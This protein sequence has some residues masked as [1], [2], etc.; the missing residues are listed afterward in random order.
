MNPQSRSIMKFMVVLTVAGLSAGCDHQLRGAASQ[1]VARTLR[2]ADHSPRADNWSTG[3]SIV[4]E[5]VDPRCFVPSQDE[6]TEVIACPRV[7][8]LQ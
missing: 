1:G 4:R 8:Q 6:N 7:T 2:T 5:S 3:P